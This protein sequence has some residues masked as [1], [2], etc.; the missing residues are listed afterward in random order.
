MKHSLAYRCSQ[1]MIM[2]Y[3]VFTLLALRYFPLPYS[4]LYNWL[5]DLGSAV[6]NPNGSAYYNVGIIATG[7]LTCLFFLGLSTWVIVGNKLQVVMLRLTQA[8]GCLGSLAMILSA[9]FP[10]NMA[11]WH[12]L[13]SGAIYILLGT[14]FAF[15]VAALRYFARFP[16]IVLLFGILVAAE[17]MAFGI[18]LNTY[19]FEWITVILFLAYVLTLGILTKRLDRFSNQGR[20]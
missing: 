1:F 8:F 12:S 18:F 9:V 4:P 7:L 19:L 20:L 14:A 13:A 16:P 15:S 2:V 10:I 6:L 11:A 17:D 5:S 3:L